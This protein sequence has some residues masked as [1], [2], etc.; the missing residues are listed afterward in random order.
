MCCKTDA[1]AGGDP[2]CI[3]RLGDEG[4][5]KSLGRQNKNLQDNILEDLSKVN[6]SSK[7]TVRVIFEDKVK[8]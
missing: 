1:C 4:I 5:N 2:T 7:P 3:T 8:K 6:K